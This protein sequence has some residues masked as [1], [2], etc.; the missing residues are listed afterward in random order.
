MSKEIKRAR[1][2][3]HDL[4]VLLCDSDRFKKMNAT[5][6]YQAG[7]E[8]LN[9]FAKILMDSVREGVDWVDRHGGEEF[10]VVHPETPF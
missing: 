6:L 5:Y 1:R 10:L 9:A 3:G 4:S 8:L 7:D 2:Y